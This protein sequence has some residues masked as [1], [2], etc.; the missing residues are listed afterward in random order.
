MDSDLSHLRYLLG[1]LLCIVLMACENF[2]ISLV[3][4]GDDDIKHKKIDDKLMLVWLLI[5]ASF[6]LLSAILC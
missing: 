2:V 3:D 5:W 1:C 4:V 6:N